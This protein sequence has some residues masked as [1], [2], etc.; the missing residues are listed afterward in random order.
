M[1]HDV[2]A[3]VAE[4]VADPPSGEGDDRCNRGREDGRPEN[5]KQ[6]ADA[7]L[8]QQIRQTAG[9]SS[10]EPSEQRLE[11]RPGPIFNRQDGQAQ[12][13]PDDDEGDEA[14]GEPERMDEK[15]DMAH[16]EKLPEN[17]LAGHG[18]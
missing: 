11:A 16:K 1:P 4:P 8:A 9:D 18:D 10:A 14:Q 3:M 5:S 13:G 2:A 17:H 7:G 6:H 12:R 15:D